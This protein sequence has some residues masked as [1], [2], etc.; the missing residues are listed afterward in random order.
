MLDTIDKVFRIIG[1]WTKPLWELPTDVREL[2]A[3]GIVFALGGLI[4][5]GAWRS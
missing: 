3:I 2:V 4:A 5:M 1:S